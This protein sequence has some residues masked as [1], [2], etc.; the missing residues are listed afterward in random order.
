MHL[1]QL[2]FPAL[3]LALLIAACGGGPTTVEQPQLPETTPPPPPPGQATSIPQATPPPGTEGAG[4]SSDYAAI[5]N[6]EPIPMATYQRML[7]QARAFFISQGMADPNTPEGQA[8]LREVARNVL[9][10][11]LIDQLLI[12]QAARRMG[13]EVTDEQ[14]EAALDA[15]IAQTG[16]QKAFEE[17]L[18]SQG[19]TLEDALRQQRERM[20]TEAVQARVVGKIGPTAEHVHVRHIVTLDEAS[21]REALARIRSGESFESVARRFSQDAATVDKGGDLGWVPRGIMGPEFDDVAFTLA[22]GE[23]S[24]VFQTPYGF[25][26]VQVVE[27]DPNRQL[28]PEHIE[29]LQREA[30]LAWLDEQRAQSDIQVFIKFIEP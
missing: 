18:A 8:F 11:Q 28:S 20:I 12:D 3:L 7:A 16:G 5:V 30:F 10:S 9:Y 4:E 24:D 19:L 26:I 17:F 29:A 22:P 2:M 13:I 14:V 23:V 15:M 21:A 25:E 1:R 27:R 6:G